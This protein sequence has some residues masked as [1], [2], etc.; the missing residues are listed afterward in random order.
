MAQK[1]KNEGKNSPQKK[2]YTK[3][4]ILDENAKEVIQQLKDGKSRS[5]IAEKYNVR[6]Q[7]VD[8]WIK[9]RN[10]ILPEKQAT[11]PSGKKRCSSCQY[12][13][14]DS[15]LGNCAYIFITGRSKRCKADN[16]DKYVKGKP[17]S[18]R[19]AKIFEEE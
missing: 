6:R 7:T 12:R 3:T 8:Y 11:A 19:R 14:L 17:L 2:S 9:K 4:S 18:K 16:C 13:Q 5:T 1:T 15:K 10:I